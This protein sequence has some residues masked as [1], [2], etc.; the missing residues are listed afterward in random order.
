[1]AR[2]HARDRDDQAA[3]GQIARGPL[4]AKLLSDRS[5]QAADRTAGAPTTAYRFEEKGKAYLP[6]SQRLSAL[7]RRQLSAGALHCE[8]LC[9]RPISTKSLARPGSLI[10]RLNLARG[11]SVVRAGEQI[12][13]RRQLAGAERAAWQHCRRFLTDVLDSQPGSYRIFG[14]M[15]T[16]R[17]ATVPFC[18]S[19]P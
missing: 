14:T 10:G 12:Q 7:L 13:T 17:L 16:G 8:D 1:L 4:P 19:R 2:P 18:C 11:H 15:G 3:F 5:Y 9:L 6:S